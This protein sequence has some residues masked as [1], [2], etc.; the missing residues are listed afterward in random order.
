MSLSSL[1]RFFKYCIYA[2]GR[3]A[4]SGKIQMFRGFLFRLRIPYFSQNVSAE[5]PI[6]CSLPVSISSR[7]WSRTPM[8]SQTGQPR[9]IKM[10]KC[11]TMDRWTW[12]L[13]DSTTSERY[14]AKSTDHLLSPPNAMRPRTMKIY[15]IDLNVIRKRLDVTVRNS[16]V[17][18]LRL[19]EI[20]MLQHWECRKKALAQKRSA[21]EQARI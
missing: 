13:R 10:H 20:E 14:F 2:Y 7:I 4:E 8:D 1:T 3:D 17:I 5:C 11:M 6:S 19:R 15:L 12:C 9:K 16:F 18:C 21:I